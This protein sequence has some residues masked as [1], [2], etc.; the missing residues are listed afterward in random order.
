MI[1][2]SEPDD[3]LLAAFVA[4]KEDA[5]FSYAAIG[6]TLRSPTLSGFWRD[7]SNVL[8]G[9]GEGVF[10]AACQAVLRGDFFPEAITRLFAAVQPVGQGDVLAAVYRLP[11]TPVRFLLPTRVIDTFDDVDDSTGQTIHRCGFTYGTL[12]GHIESG[13]ERFEVSWDRDTDEVSFMI[14]A[15]S[16]PAWW[17]VWLGLP[18]ARVEQARFRRLALAR[19]KQLV[20][21]ATKDQSCCNV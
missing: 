13:E 6:C 10:Q 8:L 16:R 19:M 3:A 9:R 7:E 20:S 15:V 4:A 14:T 12:A 21:D 11:L 17:L 1:A 18:I 2:L 5:P